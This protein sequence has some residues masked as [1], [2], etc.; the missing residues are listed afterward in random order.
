[1][2]KVS[3]V[4][5]NYNYSQYLDERIQSFLDQT[6]Q[7]FELLI[8]DNGSTDNSVDIIQKY[9]KD[10]RVSVKY[11]ADNDLPL[12][13]WNEGVDSAQGEYVMIAASDDSCDPRLLERLVEKLDD[14]P[15][16]GFAYSQSWEIDDR[17]KRLYLS[18]Q[19]M[20]HLD[21]GL[22][23]TDFVASGRDMCK[24]MLS[25]NIIRFSGM[26]RRSVFVNAGKFNVEMPYEA[27]WLLWSKILIASDLA[28]VA[29]P[30][31]FGRTHANSLG[32][33]V[34]DASVLE[35]RL[36]VIQYLLSNIEPPA[37]FWET[38]HV[39]IIGYWTRLMLS[40]QVSLNNNLRIYSLL[41]TI[42]PHLNYRFFKHLVKIFMKKLVSLYKTFLKKQ[43]VPTLN[44]T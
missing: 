7:D 17:G 14:H 33:A 42:D 15:S 2:P 30:L 41:K 22:W 23:D 1:M 21:P 6:Y 11:Y 24:H 35:G 16:V 40:G 25:L 20:D 34:K 29:E 18:K 32:K 37:Y 5:I 38:V 39:P 36:I 27:D 8:I 10:P 19:L 31:T 3:V 43:E 13:R 9:T 4:V 44:K 26:A 12:K 28:Y